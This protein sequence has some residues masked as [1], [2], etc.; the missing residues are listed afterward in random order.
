MEFYCWREGTHVGIHIIK[1]VGY[2]KN[3]VRKT[4]SFWHDYRDEFIAQVMERAIRQT[5]ENRVEWMLEE[6]YNMG[7]KDAKCKK[8]KKK[9]QFNTCVN[10]MDEE[11]LAWESD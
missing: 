6:A 2:G 1:S 3:E 10:C 11:I 5:M 7:W 8:T 4:H 9:T